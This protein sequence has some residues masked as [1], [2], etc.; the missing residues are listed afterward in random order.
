MPST[1]AGGGAKKPNSRLLAPT[2]YGIFAWRPARNAS[3]TGSGTIFPSTI[4]P[5]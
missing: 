1:A 4:G 2:M 3:S 5:E